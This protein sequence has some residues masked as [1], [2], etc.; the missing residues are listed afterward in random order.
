MTVSIDDGKYV[1]RLSLDSVQ[2]QASDN[3]HIM[4]DSHMG[5]DVLH[6]GVGWFGW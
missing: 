1:I 3:I 5:W 2:L 6:A 4:R